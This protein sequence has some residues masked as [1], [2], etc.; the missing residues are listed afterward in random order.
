MREIW[1]FNGQGAAFP[2]ALFSS[3]EKAEEW[4]ESH[5]VR[6]VLTKYPV[7]ISA[8]EQAIEEGWFTPTKEYQ[9]KGRFIEA[10]TSASMEHY[11]YG[12]SRG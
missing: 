6:G 8:Y 1:V 9:K 5:Q 2:C 3:R 10:F 7:D 12:R 11:H 4:I